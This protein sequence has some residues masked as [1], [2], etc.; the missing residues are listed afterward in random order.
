MKKLI[1]SMTVLLLVLSTVNAL[2]AGDPESAI[3]EMR[4]GNLFTGF[5]Q[6]ESF[7]GVQN[8]GEGRKNIGKK[9][10]DGYIICSFKGDRV[11]DIEENDKNPIIVKSSIK[12]LDNSLITFQFSPD[13]IQECHDLAFLFNSLLANNKADMKTEKIG[14][15]H[16]K[17]VVHY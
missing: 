13:K 8:L 6:Q 12:I 15:E 10:N 5:A 17:I 3:T 9:T 14:R 4:E 7:V 16:K 2:K 1:R 11:V